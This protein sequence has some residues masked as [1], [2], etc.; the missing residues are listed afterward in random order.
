M[1]GANSSKVGSTPA[2]S[3][4]GTSTVSV[5]G[6]GVF[7]PRWLGEVRPLRNSLGNGNAETGEK[8]LEFGVKEPFRR[9][10]R[11]NSTSSGLRDHDP[12]PSARMQVA[13]H[14][15]QQ[16]HSEL[17][18]RELNRGFLPS[19]IPAPSPCNDPAGCATLKA[20]VGS[21]RSFCR[22]RWRPKPN[23]TIRVPSAARYRMRQPGNRYV[24]P[25]CL[26]GVSI[27]RPV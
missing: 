4:P 22:S 13:I 7:C 19:A 26:F 3:S 5:S 14:R 20:C 10:M 1:A 6:N 2:D 27:C 18:R 8:P 23:P 25:W 15:V 9:A 16:I 12:I 11:C 24:A 21:V 17:V